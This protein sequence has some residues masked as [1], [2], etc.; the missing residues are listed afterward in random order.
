MRAKLGNARQNDAPYN[1][2]AGPTD[3]QLIQAA[4]MQEIRVVPCAAG[5]EAA[6]RAFIDQYWRAGHILARDEGLLRWQYDG[7]RMP[8]GEFAGVSVLLAKD[9]AQT[10]G[11]LGLIG[12]ECNLRGRVVPGVWLAVLVSVPEARRQLA[13]LKLLQ[14]VPALGYQAVWVLGINDEVKKI[15]RAW[16][17]EIL[18]DMP[19]WVGVLDVER[20]AGLVREGAAEADTAQVRGWCESY[21]VQPDAGPEADEVVE[22]AVGAGRFGAAWDACWTERLA[23]RLVSTQR[24]AAYLNW[25]YVDHPDFSYAWRIATERRTRSVLGLAVYRIESLRDRPERVLRLVEFLAVPEAAPALARSVVSAAYAQRVTLADF[26]CTA[27]GSAAPLERVGF[28]R[29]V[30]E[31]DA[32]AFPSRFQPL[33]PGAFRLRGAFWLAEELRCGVGALLTAEDF[34]VTKSDGDMDRPN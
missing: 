26:Y 4:T 2:R 20:A 9:G 5:E 34:Y 16:G 7:R 28:R 12:G 8:R 13:G 29:E 32:P 24:D 14:A 30:R 6:L 23:P 25:R 19:R 17:Y 15:Y 22:I 27:A 10:V 11:M 33:E 3:A 18:E 31:A 1:G 21:R